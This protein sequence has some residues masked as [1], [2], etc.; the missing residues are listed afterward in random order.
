MRS[1]P[2]A[3]LPR[4]A[5]AAI[6]LASLC[7]RQAFAI[8]PAAVPDGSTPA[9]HPTPIAPDATRAMVTELREIGHVRATTLFCSNLRHSTAQAA[10][11]AVAF[12]VAALAT[13]T[14]LVRFSNPPN[15]LQKMRLEH[16]LDDDLRDLADLSRNGG[17][18]LA[19]LRVMAKSAPPGQ[20]RE[21]LALRDSLDGAK[22][23]QHYLVKE[24]ARMVG[25]FAE[26]PTFSIIDTD[27]ANFITLLG[28]TPYA[29]AVTGRENENGYQA[30][31]Y[32]E[33]VGQL[34][35]DLLGDSDYGTILDAGNKLALFLPDDDRIR[36]DLAHAATHAAMALDS[37]GCTNDLTVPAADLKPL[38]GIANAR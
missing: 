38:P 6:L 12:E 35:S 17:A 21:L 9:P 7:G 10:N 37:G 18:E 19:E 36:T 24:L 28:G 3:V 29:R 25:T 31:H 23:R 16:S 4:V 13:M 30:G 26:R 34:P 15:Q 11:A 2:F 14:D 22:S 20:A 8:E 32:G 33:D 1:A 5:M 27:P